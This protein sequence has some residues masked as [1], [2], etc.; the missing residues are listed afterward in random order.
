MTE[1]SIEVRV[2]PR[3][4]ILDPQGKA[5]GGALASLG[6]SGVGEVH[7]GRIVVFSLT[8]E[9]E[10]QARESAEAMC[11]QLLANPVTEDFRITVSPAEN[12][13]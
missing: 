10:P 7:V 5:V 3:R 8:A 13:G 6:F 9:G 11:R 2:T 1:Y 4:G 12:V